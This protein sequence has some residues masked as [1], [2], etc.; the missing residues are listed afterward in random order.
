[1]VIEDEELE[2]VG[3]DVGVGVGVAAEDGTGSNSPID[4]WRASTLITSWM[5]GIG[6]ALTMEKNIVL[7]RNALGSRGVRDIIAPY[8][9]LD[10]QRKRERA[11]KFLRRFS[12]IK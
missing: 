7:I 6:V 5:M 12:W 2:G 3:V 10:Q 8:L 1:V 4:P 9:L 11:M